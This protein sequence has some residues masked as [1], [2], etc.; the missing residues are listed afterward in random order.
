MSFQKHPFMNFKQV[1]NSCKYSWMSYYSIQH[2]NKKHK[3]IKLLEGNKTV[4]TNSI[5]LYVKES[6]SESYI[7]FR[8]SSSLYDFKDVLTIL[9]QRETKGIVHKGFH[10]KYLNIQ[11]TLDNV[12][13]D[14]TSK[15][16]IFTGHSMG[17]CVALVSALKTREFLK[18]KNIDKQIYCYMFGSPCVGDK[19][20]LNYAEEHLDGLL[21]ID[22]NTDI[23]PYIPLNPFFRK[24]D[25]L[26]ILKE[27]EKQNMFQVL[28]NHSCLSYYKALHNYFDNEGLCSD[29]SELEYLIKT[30]NIKKLQ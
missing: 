2:I 6:Q 3:N 24:P 28:K 10:N 5:C 27:S 4:N 1:S 21:G 15:H 25:N 9:P 29:E 30:L 23:V 19:D 11:N 14:D 12:L 18:L 22:L 8:G 26:I 7:A 17:G 20:F 13:F 16:L